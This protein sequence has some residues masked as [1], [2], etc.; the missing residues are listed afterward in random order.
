[1]DLA[2]AGRLRRALSASV[3]DPARPDPE[4]APNEDRTRRVVVASSH[5]H[6]S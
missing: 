5:D 3:A 2:G 6:A 4:L 1:M